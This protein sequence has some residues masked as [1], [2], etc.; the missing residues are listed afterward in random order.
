MSSILVMKLFICRLEQ[1]YREKKCFNN[2]FLWNIS[3]ISAS[4]IT[5]DFLLD[6]HDI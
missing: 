2:E 1:Q 5:L 4:E 6:Q 3:G